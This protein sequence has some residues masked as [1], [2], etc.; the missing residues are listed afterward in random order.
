METLKLEKIFQWVLI[1]I[2]LLII[3]VPGLWMIFTPQVISS[4]TEKRTLAVFPDPPSSSAGIRGFFSDVD[5]YL[6]DHFGF[7]E[8]MVYRYQR[9]IKKRFADVERISKVI[10]GLDNWYFFTGDGMLEDYTGKRQLS[11][12][13]LQEWLENYR[14][15]RAWLE[16]K[17]IKYL[18]VV[19][20]NKMSI[21]DEFLGEPWISQKG[22]RRLE[23]LTEAM[24]ESDKS[25]FL[26]LTPALA[27]KGGQQ[28]LFFKSD[29]H[30]APYGAY[31][32][33]LAIADKLETLFPGSQFK[34]DFGFSSIEK[35]KCEKKA[36]NCGDLTNMLL[37]Y[38][39]FE[40]SFSTVDEFSSC[41]VP[42]E[43]DYGFSGIDYATRDPYIAKSCEQGDL[44]AL[45]FRD[46]FSRDLEPFLSENFKEV[47]YLWKGYDQKNVEELL[48]TFKPDIVIE[49]R[50]E[51]SL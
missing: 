7:R 1:V 14:A 49:E 30:W 42:Q 48:A 6:N 29:T 20:P 13:E 11:D 27:G 9:E 10:T 51:R 41:T 5:S 25:T 37:S 39:S 3:S 40:E 26:N 18:F 45:V 31:L 21:Y 28:N 12:G 17:G 38:D 35:R 19:P 44:T 2:F 33:Y 24:T 46:S 34:R 32:G 8:W 36:N 47:I 15:K 16:K 4:Y 23:Q 22:K 50:A 43:Y